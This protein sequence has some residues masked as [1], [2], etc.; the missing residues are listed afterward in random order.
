MQAYIDK[1]DIT[2]VF[3]G[4]DIGYYDFVMIYIYSS[5]HYYY[6]YIEIL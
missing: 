3:L 1:V 4:Y 2:A 6:C 5:E